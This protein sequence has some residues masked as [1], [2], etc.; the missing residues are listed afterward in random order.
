MMKKDCIDVLVKAPRCITF[1]GPKI[2]KGVYVRLREGLRSSSQF[3][4]GRGSREAKTG[5]RKTF[6]E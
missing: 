1:A 3:L 2:R 4:K 6:I 5:D